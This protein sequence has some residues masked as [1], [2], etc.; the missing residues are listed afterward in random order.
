[1]KALIINQ[2]L[3]INFNVEKAK[4]CKFKDGINVVTSNKV[5][6]KGNFVGK[7]SLLRSIYYTFGADTKFSSMW[8]KDGRNIYVIKFNVDKEFFT[9]LRYD[10]LFKLF[11]RND[12][13]IFAVSNR[14]DLAIKF[15]DL[16]G[17]N[18]YLMDHNQ[19]YVVA[20]PAINYLLNYIDQSEIK[21]CSFSSFNN[22]N[23]YKDWYSDAIDGLIGI[24]NN[25]YFEK[26]KILSEKQK[27]LESK[28][29]L[30][31]FYSKMEVKLNCIDNS[32]VIEA[33]ILNAE[34]AKYE[35]QFN[36][37]I[38]TLRKIKEK[39]MQTIGEKKKAE[40][41]LND[42]KA[43]L[44]EQNG[45]IKKILKHNCPLC[46]QELK[47]NSKL[48]FE[49]NNEAKS[50]EN[51][52]FE[53]EN[54]ISHLNKAIESERYK[55]NNLANKLRLL[56][57]EIK[58]N[59]KR[60]DNL[61]QQIGVRKIR[62]NLIIDRQNNDKEIGRLSKEINDINKELKIIDERKKTINRKYRDKIIE[63]IKKYNLASIQIEKIKTVDSKF[64][65][66]GT[67]TNI[68]LVLWLTTLLSLKY[69]YNTESLIFPLVYDTPNNANIT[70]D[71][72]KNIFEII[73]SNLPKGGQIITSTIGFD[74]NAYKD[75]K[76]N[77][78]IELTDQY[79]LL[80]ENDFKEYK[81][82]VKKYI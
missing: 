80:N 36:D 76:I 64:N 23:Q 8:E 4:F 58:E 5:D 41:L 43:L 65:P 27:E 57:S 20:A 26:K 79:S 53:L 75:Y 14:N 40:L 18:I 9:I 74:A 56:E 81:V 66:N 82:I 45:D 71:N 6:V 55:Y 33:S 12:K 3:I 21:C 54:E 25:Y 34:L 77:N 2:L 73:F 19:N 46:S 47:D 68:A 10:K 30:D 63:G 44:K 37:T 60:T 24:N 15:K 7:S 11:D 50:Y 1:M 59:N 28:K 29:E 67:E 61:F 35:S 17:F 42:F 38:E 13:L 62:E 31:N 70:V 39:L 72:E 78:I 49:Q 22:L 52:I 32:P 48:F 69:E 16:F 51:S